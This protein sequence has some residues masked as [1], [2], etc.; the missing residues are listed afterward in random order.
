MEVHPDG[1]FHSALCITVHSTKSTRHPA[2][3]ELLTRFT[4]LTCTSKLDI[5]ITLCEPTNFPSCCCNP[6]IRTVLQPGGL[7]RLRTLEH[8]PTHSLNP[9]FLPCCPDGRLCG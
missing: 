7:S 2:E 8:I 9:L 6:L 1:N 4:T 3:A 5:A